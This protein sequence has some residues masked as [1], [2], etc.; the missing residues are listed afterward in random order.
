MFL[1]TASLLCALLC[2]ADSK[3]RI[4]LHKVEKTARQSIAEYAPSKLDKLTD[5]S[6][7][8]SSDGNSKVILK[9][10]LDAQYYGIITLGTPGNSF[11]HLAD[12]WESLSSLVGWVGG[13]VVS[14]ITYLF[15]Y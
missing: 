15:I 10:Y 7:L 6:I 11:G 14:R 9:N 13:Y 2:V 12:R 4:K 1:G 8:S 3:V 5:F